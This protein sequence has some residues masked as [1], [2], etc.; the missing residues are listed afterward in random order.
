MLLY[1][2]FVISLFYFAAISRSAIVNIRLYTLW[3]HSDVRQSLGL[4]NSKLSRCTPQTF[5]C[6]PK[7]S[8]L[9][10]NYR[11]INRPLKSNF[12]SLH[13]CKAPL[14]TVD[15]NKSNRN[16]LVPIRP[17]T[18]SRLCLDNGHWQCGHSIDSL[19][20]VPSVPNVTNIDCIQDYQQFIV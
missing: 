17:E 12:E 13:W 11:L 5:A 15:E 14:F 6:Q 7:C 3:A 9:D 19:I 16:M 18:V 1:D 10:E 8:E 2:R 4:Q 20:P